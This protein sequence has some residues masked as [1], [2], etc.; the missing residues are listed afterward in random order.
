MTTIQDTLTYA[1]GSLVNGQVVVSTGPFQI[2]GV[3][4]A[5]STETYQI[6]NGNITIQLYANANAQPAGTYYT[7]KYELENGAVYEEYWIVPNLPLVNLGQCRVLFPPTPSVLISATQLMSTG[8]QPGMILT[9]NGSHWVPAYITTVNLTPNTIALT[10]T[11]ATASDLAV[12]GSP[13]VL[14]SSLT[15]NVPDAGPASRGVVTTGAQTFAG[16]K[17]F[18][19]VAQF[20]NGVV[21][22]A[23]ATIAGYVPTTRQII[24]GYGLTGG[25][26]LSA[27]CTLAVVDRA[28]TQKIQVDN[29]NTP[30]GTQGELNFM[31]GANVNLTVVNDA[32]HNRVN[33]TIASVAG[34]NASYSV[35]GTLI[36]SQPGLNLIAGANTTITGVNN[37][38]ASR[39]DV[40]IAATGGVPPVTSVF[41][42]TG[43]IVAVAGDYTA[44][45]VTNAVDSTGAYANPAWITSLAWSKITG[46]PAYVPTS[47]Q[48]IAGTG[49]TGGGALTADVMLAAIPMGASG[50]S[51]SAGMVGDPAPRAAQPGTGARMRPGLFLL[52]RAAG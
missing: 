46:A 3:S 32:A 45:Q 31:P 24:A 52:A 33:V 41:T 11:N 40:T 28:S 8:A 47:R 37:T 14:G 21:I 51:H 20:P 5:G 42:R 35:N 6:V 23:P 30:V 18:E 38:G 44:A 29:N 48:V 39:V 13:A 1:D 12:N 34:S 17:T 7:A 27:D 36:A 49:L 22:G 2:S 16:V 43:A 19:G 15:L 9:W 26:D 50:A 25:G 10:L 4:V